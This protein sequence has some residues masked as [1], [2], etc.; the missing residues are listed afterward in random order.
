MSIIYY[1]DEIMGIK[2][3]TEFTFWLNNVGKILDSRELLD[4]EKP[5]LIL[6][7]VFGDEIFNSD[8]DHLKLF[9]KTMDFYNCGKEARGIKPPNET[10]LHWEK[11][12]LNILSDFLLYYKIDI[13]TVNMH[14]WKFHSMFE[15]LPADSRIKT[16]MQIRGEDL[17]EYNGK[18][19]AK[20]R[21]NLCERKKIAA[22]WPDEIIEEWGD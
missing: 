16:L 14:W 20:T 13:E 5:E 6:S 17:S 15:S 22:V 8:I 7:N 11:D 1:P 10:I 21:A 2:I 4:F 19:Q 9:E 12:M 3:N 18:D